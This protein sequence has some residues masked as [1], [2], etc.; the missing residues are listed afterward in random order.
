M[1]S[2]KIYP[3]L[4]LQDNQPAEVCVRERAIVQ[5]VLG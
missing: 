2:Q 5:K 4:L 3:L 1:L